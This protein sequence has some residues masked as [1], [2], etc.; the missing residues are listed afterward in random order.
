MVRRKSPSVKRPTRLPLAS[1]TRS[2]ISRALADKGRRFVWIARG[3]TPR[4]AQ[5]RVSVAAPSD[6]PGNVALAQARAQRV[7]A[8]IRQGQ[9][10]HAHYDSLLALAFHGVFEVE[11]DLER[12]FTPK[13]AIGF[14]SERIDELD[15]IV[16]RRA[17]SGETL[18]GLDGRTHEFDEAMVVIADDAGGARDFRIGNQGETCDALPLGGGKWMVG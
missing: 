9:P 18:L 10:V 13:S 3:L 2:A 15:K 1:T 16:V 14:D 7:D 4:Q 8:G 5:A 11:V 17:R 12:A 6:G